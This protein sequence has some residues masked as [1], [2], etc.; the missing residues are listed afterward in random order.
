MT[1]REWTTQDVVTLLRRWRVLIVIC[2]VAGALLAYGVSRFIPNRYK[3]QTTVLVEQPTVPTDFVR[4]VVS[5]D[6]NERLASMKQQILSR[7]RLEPIIR[8][9]GLYSQDVNR[10]SMEDLVTRLQSA[11][12]VTPI[13]PLVESEAFKMPGFSISVIW[14]N[15]GTAQD[16]CT[17]VTSMFIQES[18]RLRQEHSEDTTKFMAQELADAKAKLD[19]QDAKLAEFESHHIGSLPDQVQENFGTLSGLYTQ[20]D[21]ATQA[22]TRAQLDKNLAQSQLAQQIAA[23]KASQTGENPETFEEQLAALQT[24]LATLQAHYTDEYPDVVKTKIQIEALKKKIAESD[25]LSKSAPLDE[26][27]KGPMEPMQFTQLRAQIRTDDEVIAE[28]TKQQEQIQ[29]Q[30]KTVQARVQASPATE[31]QYK[32]LTRDYQTALEFYKDLLNKRSQS[33]MATDLE[34]RQEGEQF[35]MLDPANLPDKPYFPDRLLFALGGLGGGLALG[36]GLAFLLEMRDTSLR[37]ERDVESSLRLPVLAMV[38][39][40]EPVSG[41]RANQLAIN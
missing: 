11:I 7:T 36:L 39:V 31:Q 35:R 12:V 1:Q 23:R 21:A 29:G 6:I 2:A 28:K 20:L 3:S 4:P 34:R 37:T 15:P 9:F 30:I 40:I 32:E 33:A 38:P 16:V 22:L 25:D 10:V 27:K 18:I 19:E 17:A 8:Q 26:N 13:L 41:K 5:E 14:D 24:Q